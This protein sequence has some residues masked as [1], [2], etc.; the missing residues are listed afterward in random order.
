MARFH[1]P[2][3][4]RVLLDGVDLRS[5]AT[6]E[7]RHGVVMVSQEG[8]LFSGTVAEN[9]A[10]ARPDPRST[11]PARRGGGSISPGPRCA[12]AIPSAMGLPQGRPRPRGYAPR[13]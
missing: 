11:S 7:L 10:L 9:I 6:A 5:L 2:T 13:T 8:F 12:P 3:G 4:G 1:D